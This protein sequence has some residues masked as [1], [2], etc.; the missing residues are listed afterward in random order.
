MKRVT[1]MDL[2]SI[3]YIVAYQN[4]DSLFDSIVE[5]ATE[6][7]IDTLLDKTAAEGYT[8][9]YQVEGH[10]NYRLDILPTYKAN[11]PETSDYV[12]KWRPVIHSVFDRYKGIV[13]LK[14]IESDDAL[15]IINER[16]KDKYDLTFARIDKDLRCIPGLHF[17]YK[18]FKF[19]D[20]STEDAISFFNAQVLAG[21][22]GDNIKSIPGVGMKTAEK[23]LKMEPTMI[24]AYR[25]ACKVKKVDRWIQTFYES[26]HCIRLLKSLEEL[27][28]H[29]DREEVNI[30]NIDLYEYEESQEDEVE[31]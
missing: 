17:N 20:I 16:F 5:E 4:Q 22:N 31:W 13:G 26:Y 8:G 27:K 6:K 18:S 23:F 19:E 21:D 24:R 15:S 2:D 30:Y 3:V 28:Q 10:K 25:T 29:T 1:V 9:F 12:K 11:R 14:V 7:F